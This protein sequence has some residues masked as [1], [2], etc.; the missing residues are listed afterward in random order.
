MKLADKLCGV[1]MNLVL[2]WSIICMIIKSKEKE[3]LS[4][5]DG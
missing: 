3:I 4:R 2:N 5:L 1:K